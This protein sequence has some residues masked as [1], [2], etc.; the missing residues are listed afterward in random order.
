MKTS[1]T[2]ASTLFTL[3]L[4]APLLGGCPKTGGDK[5]DGAAEAGVAAVVAAPPSASVAPSAS[6][7]PSADPKRACKP[8][9]TLVQLFAERGFEFQCK[10]VCG[11]GF[12]PVPTINCAWARRGFR[13][14]TTA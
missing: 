12:H 9:L 3:V 13:A 6:A 11:G 7:A 8:G 10:Q 2:V 4:V 5:A 14:S 1:T